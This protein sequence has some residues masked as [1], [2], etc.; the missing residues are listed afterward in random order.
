MGGKM[1]RRTNG[2]VEMRDGWEDGQK[3]EWGWR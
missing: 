1:D 3:Y 2:G